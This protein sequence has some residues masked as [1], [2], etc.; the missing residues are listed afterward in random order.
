MKADRM[1][2]DSLWFNDVSTCIGVVRVWDRF[3]GYRYYIGSTVES[4]SRSADEERIMHWGAKFPVAAGDELF[5]ITSK[6][7]GA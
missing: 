5:G 2:V 4:N 6:K 3:D 7:E 1:V